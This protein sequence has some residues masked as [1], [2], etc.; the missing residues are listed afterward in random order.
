MQPTTIIAI[1]VFLVSEGI[2]LNAFFEQRAALD[3]SRQRGEDLRGVLVPSWYSKVNIFRILSW[4][5]LAYL[6]FTWV[7]YWP[8]IALIISFV[9]TNV[10]PVPKRK[11]EKALQKLAKLDAESL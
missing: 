9:I 7:W 4:A 5:A 3:I 10:V 6:F 11:Y 2:V 8:V 1:A